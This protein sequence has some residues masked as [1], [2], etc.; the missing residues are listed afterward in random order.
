[1]KDVKLEK[2]QNTLFPIAVTLLGMTVFTHPA[3]SVLDAVSIIALQFSRESYTSLFSSTII[4]VSQG[5]Q[6]STHSPMLLTLLGIVKEVKLIQS[7]NA[8]SP[9]LVTLLGMVTEVILE[10]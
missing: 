3:I 2:P 5:H 9:I 10:Q 4:D 7:L 1:M 6:A 8:P